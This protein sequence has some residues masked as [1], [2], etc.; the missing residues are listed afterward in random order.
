[1][2]SRKCL[3]SAKILAMMILMI[4]ISINAAPPPLEKVAPS[5]IELR[6]VVRTPNENS[7]RKFHSQVTSNPDLNYLKVEPQDLQLNQGDLSAFSVFLA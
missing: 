4:I 7:A 6:R 5:T 3:P 1:M 2:W